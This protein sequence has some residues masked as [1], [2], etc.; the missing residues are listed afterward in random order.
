MTTGLPLLPR[1]EILLWI[2]CTLTAGCQPAAKADMEL[3]KTLTQAAEAVAPG[4]LLS[5][6]KVVVQPWD[7]VLLVGPYTPNAVIQKAT[8]GS[9]PAE[10][11]RLEIDKRDD[12]NL[13]I[14]MQ[15][16]KPSTAVALPRRVA[17]FDKADLLRPTERQKAQLV[18]AATGVGFRWQAP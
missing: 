2:T 3:T 13:L 7:Q 4:Q 1:R 12:V 14:F 16:G 11:E 6:D 5:L 9:L 18:R 15:G 10:L 17:D 8:G